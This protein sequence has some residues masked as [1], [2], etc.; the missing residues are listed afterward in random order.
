[1]S[2]KDRMYSLW[3]FLQYTHLKISAEHSEG[4]FLDVI[5]EKS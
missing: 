1:M 5:G 3:Y 2:E 4:V